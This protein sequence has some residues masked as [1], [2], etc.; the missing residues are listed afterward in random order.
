MATTTG[1]S[2]STGGRPAK[3]SLPA[4]LGVIAGV[5]RGLSYEDAAREAGVGRS[6]AFRWLKDARAGEPSLAGF[7]EALAQAERDHKAEKARGRQAEASNLLAGVLGR[8]R[9]MSRTRRICGSGTGPYPR[10]GKETVSH[11][12]ERPDSPPASPATGT[13]GELAAPAPGDSGPG[14]RWD[15]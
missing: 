10:N 14:F 15:Q 7:V 4:V 13:G 12:S 9:R 8:G 3:L 5:R 2:K 11:D 1:P 6:T